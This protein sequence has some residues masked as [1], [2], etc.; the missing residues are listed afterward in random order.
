VTTDPGLL[1]SPCAGAL[2]GFLAPGT[3]RQKLAAAWL[4]PSLTAS[5][6]RG[7]ARP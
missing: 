5:E 4:D 1:L 3:A 7:R 2:S 6:T